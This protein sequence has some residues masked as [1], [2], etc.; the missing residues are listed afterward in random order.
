MEWTPND[1]ITQFF[2]YTN[3]SKRNIELN[4]LKILYEKACH[5]EHFAHVVKELFDLNETLK[6]RLIINESNIR[7]VIQQD[8]FLQIPTDDMKKILTDLDEMRFAKRKTLD[9]LLVKVKFLRERYHNLLM[10]IFA[11][12][13]HFDT[14]DPKATEQESQIRL[15]AANLNRCEAAIRNARN[16]HGYYFRI[17][18]YLSKDNLDNNRSLEALKQAITEQTQLIKKTT[19]IGRSMINNVAKLNIDLKKSSLKFATHRELTTTSLIHYKTILAKEKSSIVDATM[20]DIDTKRWTSRYDSLTQSMEN[21]QI[22]KE[23]LQSTILEMKQ[24]SFSICE[25]QILYEMNHKT[26]QIMQVEK[27]IYEK[28]GSYKKLNESIEHMKYF[29]HEGSNLPPKTENITHG[30]EE[31]TKMQ[32]KLK[33]SLA[34]QNSLHMLLDQFFAHITQIIERSD[35]KATNVNMHDSEYEN[36]ATLS[37][38]LRLLKS[39]E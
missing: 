8:Q 19:Q 22:E 30:L 27:E 7:N 11:N 10:K 2:N 37:A 15:L 21:L 14:Y 1:R 18:M 3:L 38:L 24:A 39:E 16:V 34:R 36:I 32:T 17:G 12:R 28:E 13:I 4:R 9:L 6:R 20:K 33:A 23:N 26:N 25:A 29:I 35:L 5:S 31:Q